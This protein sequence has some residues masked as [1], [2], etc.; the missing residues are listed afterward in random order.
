[1]SERG[2]FVT[3]YIYC[4]KC[5][6]AVKGV[7][8]DRDKYLCSVQIPSWTEQEIPIIAGKIGGLGSGD[9]VIEFEFELMPRIE[10]QICHSVVVCIISDSS[11][12]AVFRVFPAESPDF[13]SFAVKVDTRAPKEQ[14]DDEEL[15]KEL[16]GGDLKII[17]PIKE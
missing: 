10:K 3:E 7:L 1:M 5:F 2:S 16:S 14:A 4:P 11:G 17:V 8:L 12:V 9:E 13:D 6:E 15:Q